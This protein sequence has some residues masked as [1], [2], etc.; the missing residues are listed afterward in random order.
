MTDTKP[1]VIIGDPAVVCEGDYCEIPEHHEQAIVN[2]AVD[3]GNI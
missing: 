3:T 1:L 2:R